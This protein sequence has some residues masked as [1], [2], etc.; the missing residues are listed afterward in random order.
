MSQWAAHVESLHW[1]G[2]WPYTHTILHAGFVQ[3]TCLVG[4]RYDIQVYI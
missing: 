2:G 4:K 1:E 3:L